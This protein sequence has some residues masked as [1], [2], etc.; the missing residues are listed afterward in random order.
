MAKGDERKGWS[1]LA[2]LPLS[3][4]NVV[5]KNVKHVRTTKQHL[6]CVMCL[7][8]FSFS[9]LELVKHNGPIRTGQSKKLPRPLPQSRLLMLVVDT[10]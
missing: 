10:A 7:Y 4:K 1:S 3:N 2:T 8:D 5:L 9:Y 6:F